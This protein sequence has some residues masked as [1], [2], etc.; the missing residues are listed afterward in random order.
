MR[1]PLSLK[2]KLTNDILGK[3]VLFFTEKLLILLTEK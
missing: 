1:T 2:I 3:K